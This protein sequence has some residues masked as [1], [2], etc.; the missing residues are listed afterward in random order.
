MRSL[1]SS[2]SCDLLAQE[3]LV[4]F[5]TCFEEFKVLIGIF[6]E[7]TD[8]DSEIVVFLED[9]SLNKLFLFFESHLQ[10]VV[11]VVDFPID[12][13]LEFVEVLFDCREPT[14]HILAVLLC[15]LK[16]IS[17]LFCQ[18]CENTFHLTV[19]LSDNLDNF[20]NFGIDV[21]AQLARPFC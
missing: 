14:L 3:I 15:V 10:V 5:N 20:L 2:E 11:E 19:L 4:V 7:F 21:V 9:H 12:F 17:K 16:M 1:S 18:L 8:P 13:I 6:F